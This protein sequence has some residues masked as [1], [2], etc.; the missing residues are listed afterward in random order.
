MIDEAE[1]P[2]PAHP[3]QTHRSA[4]D[5]E[6]RAAAEALHYP[7]AL[8]FNKGH[9]A[10]KNVDKPRHSHRHEHLTK[11]T[12]F[13]QDMIREVCSFTSYERYIMELLWVSTDKWVL[14]AIKKSVET[15]ICAKRKR[16]ELSNVLVTMKKVAAKKD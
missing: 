2:P 5:Y 1:P 7:A 4:T 16:E 13:M 9:K 10:I 15:Y 3:H 11:H 14:K 6:M 12:N 8:S